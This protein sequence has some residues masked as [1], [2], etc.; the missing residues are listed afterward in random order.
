GGA[1]TQG[2]RGARAAL[3]LALALALASAAAREPRR[4]TPWRSPGLPHPPPHLAPA[5]LLAVHEHAEAED[6]AGEAAEEVDR[7]DE[8]CCGE[9]RFPTGCFRDEPP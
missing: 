1:P 7:A 5:R 3:S 9:S 8:E 4:P 2:R 6:A